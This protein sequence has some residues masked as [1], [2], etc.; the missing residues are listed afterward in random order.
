[1]QAEYHQ[2]VEKIENQKIHVL[3]QIA[4]FQGNKADDRKLIEKSKIKS[5]DEELIKSVN[6]KSEF[7]IP[8]DSNYFNYHGLGLMSARVKDANDI[9]TL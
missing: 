9:V 1:M 5:L 4:K 6:R 2:I 8:K 3:E 7:F